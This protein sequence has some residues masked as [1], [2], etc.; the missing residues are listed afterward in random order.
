MSVAQ[1]DPDR[2]R[3]ER[4]DRDLD[5]KR[6]HQGPQRQANRAQRAEHGAA[7]FEREADG[8]VHDEK[9]DAEGQEAEGSEVQVKAVGQARDI[10]RTVG[11]FQP[12]GQVPGQ[13]GQ[14]GGLVRRDDQ[15]IGIGPVQK[16]RS[17]GDVCDRGGGGTRC[18]G[19]RWAAGQRA[20]HRS[21]WPRTSGGGRAP[22][23]TPPHPECCHRVS[24]RPFPPG[25]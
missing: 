21:P 1:D 2:A 4:H 20:G 12:Q 25:R 22:P 18:R 23:E 15:V 13:R 9:T 8:G 11:R 19:W 5:G 10:A 3:H 24:A 16:A 14:I 6:G 7:L 17:R